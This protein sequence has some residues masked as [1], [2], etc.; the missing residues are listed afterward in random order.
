MTETSASD[1]LI[2]ATAL[3]STTDKHMQICQFGNLLLL[4]L[5]LSVISI[6]PVHFTL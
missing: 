3:S 5:F 1:Y 6:L 2:S 4:T